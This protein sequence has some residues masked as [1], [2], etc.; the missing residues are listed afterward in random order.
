MIETKM[1]EYKKI[2]NVFMSR[3]LKKSAKK[4]KWFFV[5]QRKIN[6]I[7]V[8]LEL[9]RLEE[10]ELN[11]K[12][13]TIDKWLANSHFISTWMKK[14]YSNEEHNLIDF[15]DRLFEKSSKLRILLII[16]RSQIDD[17]FVKVFHIL[18]H[19]EINSRTNNSRRA[20]SYYMMFHIKRSSIS[21]R[22]IEYHTLAW[23]RRDSLESQSTKE[24]SNSKSIQR[25]DQICHDVTHYLRRRIYRL[26]FSIAMLKCAFLWKLSKSIYEKSNCMS[27][28]TSW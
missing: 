20:K 5:E 12:T 19:I 27:F 6:M 23:C 15:L 2:E 24:K 14:L 7:C 11:L 21:F 9:L 26:Q 8:W 22:R 3:L 18:D 16:I 28:S 25:E 1:I 17:L 4:S 13:T 10:L